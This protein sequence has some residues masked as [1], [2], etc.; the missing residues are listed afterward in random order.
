MESLWH[1]WW[2]LMTLSYCCFRSSLKIL[3]SA[4]MEMLWKRIPYQKKTRYFCETSKSVCSSTL[5]D[6][7]YSSVYPSSWSRSKCMQ[8]S[9][10]NSVF[11]SSGQHFFQ[12][13]KDLQFQYTVIN[14]YIISTKSY[15]SVPTHCLQLVSFVVIAGSSPRTSEKLSL[16]GWWNIWNFLPWFLFENNFSVTGLCLHPLVKVCWVGPSC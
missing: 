6:G 2:K 11:D 10:N 5:F 15:F 8:I 13:N 9:F 4:W 12:A 7:S 16:L 3:Q 14:K 1:A